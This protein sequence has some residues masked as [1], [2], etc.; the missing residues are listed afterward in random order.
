M[1][2]HQPFDISTMN[3]IFIAVVVVVISISFAFLILTES[4]DEKHYCDDYD[5]DADDIKS[6]TVEEIYEAAEMIREEPDC[7]GSEAAASLAA[8]NEGEKEHIEEYLPDILLLVKMPYDRGCDLLRRYDND[9]IQFYGW[10]TNETKRKR[11][12]SI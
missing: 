7:F 9:A 12:Q 6:E 10:E 3:I 2:S 4:D 1:T 8:F 5:D 11:S